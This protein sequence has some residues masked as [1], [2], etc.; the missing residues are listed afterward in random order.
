MSTAY[1]NSRKDAVVKRGSS[2]GSSLSK[3]AGPTVATP[4]TG[5]HLRGMTPGGGQWEGWV[6]D[7][8]GEASGTRRCEVCG[9]G[10]EA[11]EASGLCTLPAQTP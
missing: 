10:S 1:V 5:A 8:R 6:E 3:D 11:G 4:C 9:A 2:P 7:P